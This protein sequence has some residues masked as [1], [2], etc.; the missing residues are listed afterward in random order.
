MHLSER[1]ESLD[2]SSQGDF[3]HVAFRSSGLRALLEKLESRGIEH[4][5]AYLEDR[6]MSQVFFRSPSNLRIEV[7][8]GGEKT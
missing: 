1:A 3:D 8:F 5:T 6:D 4:A 2:D 7:N